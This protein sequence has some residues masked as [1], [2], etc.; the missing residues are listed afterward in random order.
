MSLSL[1][2]RVTLFCSGGYAELGI[3]IPAILS[4]TKSILTFRLSG[5]DV[6]SLDLGGPF[7]FMALLGM[8][9]LLV[10]CRHYLVH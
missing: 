10:R 5:R 3:D 4:R 2:S 9:H 7:I 1:F 6:T 8:A